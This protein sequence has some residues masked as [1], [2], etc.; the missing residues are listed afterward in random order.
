MNTLKRTHGTLLFSPE[1][2]DRVDLEN[3]VFGL[4]RSIDPVLLERAATLGNQIVTPSNALPAAAYED[5]SG[6]PH[7]LI[8]GAYLRCGGRRPARTRKGTVS[9][10]SAM[11]KG[12]AADSDFMWDLSLLDERGIRAYSEG[13]VMIK[14]PSKGS[15]EVRTSTYSRY[16]DAFIQRLITVGDATEC[17][18]GFVDGWDLYA[19]EPG[20][21][22]PG[23]GWGT[24]IPG[25][26]MGRLSPDRLEA[27]RGV[28]YRIREL[29]N[30]GVW[31]QVGREP[32]P[33]RENEMK[34]LLALVNDLLPRGWHKVWLEGQRSLRV[35]PELGS[36][37]ELNY[38]ERGP[39]VKYLED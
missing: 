3:V 25:R 36:Y 23:L 20:D 17:Q 2:L 22:L 12:V 31:V 4:V 8:A 9:A 6:P 10:V 26:F 7:G 24:F 15:L 38:G 37:F 29:S 35:D 1:W 18:G 28:L 5:P 21:Y 14:A 39:W 19:T 33:L 34:V 13:S 30:G 16:C 32:A 27:A 11:L